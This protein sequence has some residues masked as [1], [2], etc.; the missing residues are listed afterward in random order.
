MQPSIPAFDVVG[1]TGTVIVEMI[2]LDYF[3]GVGQPFFLKIFSEFTKCIVHI[4]K[5][6]DAGTKT[7]Y[8]EKDIEPDETHNGGGTGKS[9]R[10]TQC[11]RDKSGKND[12]GHR[13][14][15]HRPF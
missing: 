12:R 7:V 4:G 11:F 8:G 6:E 1:C 10:Q 13:D 15:G 3:R 14:P 2:P 5:A 9:G